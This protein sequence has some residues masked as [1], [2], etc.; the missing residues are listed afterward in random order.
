MAHKSENGRT[1]DHRI[2]TPVWTSQFVTELSERRPGWR[3]LQGPG[4]QGHRLTITKRLKTVVSSERIHICRFASL[5]SQTF[6][7]L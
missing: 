5:D 4:T 3:E 2:S 7:P 1:Q 6:S